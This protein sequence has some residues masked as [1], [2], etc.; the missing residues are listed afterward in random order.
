ML[1]P[2][3]SKKLKLSNNTLLGGSYM[4]HLAEIK[5]VAERKKFERA[6]SLVEGRIKDI[7][8]GTPNLPYEKTKL[9]EVEINKFFY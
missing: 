3:E 1:K 8:A 5:T 2:I 7:R 4:T 6:L 9:A